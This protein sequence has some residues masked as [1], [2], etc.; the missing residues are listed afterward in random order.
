M[1]RQITLKD[2]IFE[3]RLVMNRAIVLLILGGLLLMVLLTR[4][5]YLQ[6]KTATDTTQPWSD[7]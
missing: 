6:R 1:P 4:L 2:H 3:S 5:L 7:F